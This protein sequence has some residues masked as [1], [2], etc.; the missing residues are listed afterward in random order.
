L[1]HEASKKVDA[2]V[3]K[4]DIRIDEIAEAKTSP[5]EEMKRLF[6]EII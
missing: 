1:L 2:I 4:A 5:Y 3:S 6:K